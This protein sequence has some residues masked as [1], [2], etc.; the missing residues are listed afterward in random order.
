MQ[1]FTENF[2]NTFSVPGTMVNAEKMQVIK[3][4]EFLLSEN[5]LD[6]GKIQMV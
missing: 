1:I 5:Y 6:K 2:R 4:A 3:T